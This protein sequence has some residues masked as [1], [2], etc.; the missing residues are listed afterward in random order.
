MIVAT[1]RLCRQLIQSAPSLPPNES[2]PPQPP[3]E[4]IERAGFSQ[5]FGLHMQRWHGAELKELQGLLAKGTELGAS[6]AGFRALLWAES[7]D[8]AWIAWRAR[9]QKA[10]SDGLME[11]LLLVK[12]VAPNGSTA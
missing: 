11:L 6:V 12:P 8:P 7:S 1:C 3:P 4:E 9:D 2:Q 10:I 5:A